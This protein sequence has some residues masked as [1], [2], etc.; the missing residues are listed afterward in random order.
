MS[1]G[2]WRDIAVVL[3]ALEAFLG[4]LVAGAACYFSIRGVLWL[5][6]NI[7]RV[8]RPARHYLTQTEEVVRRAGTSAVEPFIWSGATVARVRAAWHR[9]KRPERRTSHV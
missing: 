4:V 6:A 7:P 8:T 2:F 9:L 3:L 5:K 1:L